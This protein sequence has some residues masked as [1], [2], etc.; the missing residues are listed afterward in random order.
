MCVLLAIVYV[1]SRTGDQEAG[2]TAAHSNNNIRTKQPNDDV[3]ASMAT[4][5]TPPV[6]IETTPVGDTSPPVVVPAVVTATTPPMTTV[7]FLRQ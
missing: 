2:A 5:S 1:L 6:V 3:P 7:L 4:V